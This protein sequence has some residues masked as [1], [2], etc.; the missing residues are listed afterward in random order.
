M[1]NL[2]QLKSEFGTDHVYNCDT[3]NEMVPTS[4]NLTYLADIGKSVYKAMTG[5]D[6]QAIW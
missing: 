5:A 4:S 1:T 2:F 3:F 6:P